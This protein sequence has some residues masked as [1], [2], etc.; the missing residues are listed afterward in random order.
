MGNT[1]SNSTVQKSLA[2]DKEDTS[3]ILLGDT[4]YSCS[5][6][7]NWVLISKRDDSELDCSPLDEVFEESHVDIFTGDYSRTIDRGI[8]N[9]KSKKKTMLLRASIN[10]T[11]DKCASRCAL[12]SIW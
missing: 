9:I 4:Y 11:K 10:L 3:N 5:T 7:S 1:Y 6:N 8:S 2:T 12:L